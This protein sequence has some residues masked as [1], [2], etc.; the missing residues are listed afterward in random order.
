MKG[1]VQEVVPGSPT[2]PAYSPYQQNRSLSEISQCEIQTL[3]L[4]K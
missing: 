1:E 2:G 4:P 3:N